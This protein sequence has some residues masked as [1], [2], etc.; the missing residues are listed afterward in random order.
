MSPVIITNRV[1]P[2]YVHVFLESSYPGGIFVLSFVY[3]G[4]RTSL[5]HEN[6]TFYLFIIV[7]FDMLYFK[8]CFSSSYR[9]DKTRM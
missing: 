7:L 2:I 6:T 4:Y 9:R 5:I 1:L 8:T 3:F